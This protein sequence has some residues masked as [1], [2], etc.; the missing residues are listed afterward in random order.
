MARALLAKGSTQDGMEQRSITGIVAHFKQ[1]NTGLHQTTYQMNIRPDLWR[2]TLTLCQN[3]RIFQQLD[4]AAIITTLLKEH[5]IRDVVFSLRHSHPEQEFCVQY[6]ESDFDFLQRLTI[7]YFFE[8][9]N[10][11]NTLVFANDADS[12]PPGITLPHQPVEISNLGEPSVRNLM[13]SAQV[14]P[15]MVQ[16]KDYTFKNPAWAAEFSQQMKEDIVAHL[17]GVGDQFFSEPLTFERADLH[18][19]HASP[20]NSS[21]V[22]RMRSLH[23]LVLQP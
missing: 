13:Y 20:L 16:L 9:G 11:R 22:V 18:A 14:R 4:I 7:F 3:S 1:G 21:T 8:C 15:A 6:K 5:G 10:G 12:V 19:I 2:T 23:Y 17:S